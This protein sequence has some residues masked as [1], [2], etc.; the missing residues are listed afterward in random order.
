[1]TEAEDKVFYGGFDRLNGTFS[2]EYSSTLS[3]L[4]M[5]HRLHRYLL[6]NLLISFDSVTCMPI[7]FSLVAIELQ[8]LCSWLLEDFFSKGE[9]NNIGKK[10][11]SYS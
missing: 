10:I 6:L 3:L 7:R 2:T 8:K 9:T 4:P 5:Y 1:M 11:N